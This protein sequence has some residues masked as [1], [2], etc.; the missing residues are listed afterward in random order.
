M[1]VSL[2]PMQRR[3]VSS[4]LGDGTGAA[5]DPG[6]VEHLRSHLE[7]GLADLAAGQR[8]QLSKER[9]NDLDRCEGSFAAALAGERP[10]FEPTVRNAVGVLLHGAL[11][12][13]AA[14]P[15]QEDPQ[16]L[17]VAACE[18]LASDRRFGPFWSNLDQEARAM[19]AADALS[20]VEL[21]RASFP[22]LGPARRLLAPTAERWVGASLAGGRVTLSGRIDLMVG[23]FEPRR[24]TRVLVDLKT[25]GAWP[26]H[27]EDMRLYAL[28]FTLRF[29]VPPLR[30][31]SFFLRSGES[32]P[33]DVSE[34]MLRRAADRVV[35]AARTA[36][37]IGGPAQAAGE[38]ALR[39]GPYCDWCPRKQGCPA[40]RAAFG[41][42]PPVL[43][44]SV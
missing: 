6:L 17:V 26:E 29:G 25:G 7:A 36:A 44:G 37:R 13:D 16:A 35:H 21:F 38:L 10:P 4:L 28:L 31:A 8:I 14:S 2:T 18:G 19:I 32:Q 1:E 9:L 33:E 5:F 20:G 42:G 34:P 43:R 23:R 3:T 41:L 39:P 15:A 11:E 27:A 24:A 12:A 22:P 30:V 40:A